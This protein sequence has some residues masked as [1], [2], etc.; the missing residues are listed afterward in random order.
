VNDERTLAAA[1]AI[2]HA[3][4]R[5]RR[6][7]SHVA[8]VDLCV[9][10]RARPCMEIAMGDTESGGAAANLGKHCYE[11]RKCYTCCFSTL[12][13]IFV[14]LLSISWDTIAPTEYGLLRNGLTGTVDMTTVYRSGRYFTGPNQRFI[15]FPANQITLSYGNR[16]SLGVDEQ[17]EIRARTGADSTQGAASSGGQPVTFSL[18]F[19]YTL[20]PQLV[21][22]VYQTFGTQ[23]ETPYLRFSQQAI[24]NVA[25]QFTPRAFWNER[26]SVERAMLD[27]VNRTL[28][29]NGFATC[30]QLQLRSVG[31]QS[32]YEQTIINIQLQ[33]QLRVTKSYQLEVTRV[34]KEVDLMQSE[35]DAKVV[36]V[37]AEAA[38]ERAVI[39]GEANAKAL[40]REQS[41]RATMY[42]RLR[43]HL[44]WSA[45]EFLQY[46]K[47][48]A[49]NSQPQ[50]NVVVGVNPLGSVV[51]A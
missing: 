46:I 15:R 48:K 47:M 17:A 33:E 29:D 4:L 43:S 50:S 27:A 21:P 16:T 19:Q 34:V 25:Q 11:Q 18:S 41:A 32:S 22:Q 24:T 28:F 39:E 45:A 10:R 14:I 38:R 20:N 51:A 37:N 49:L 31:F 3:S 12:L 9:R 8:L 30:T 23:W 35:T 40:Q 2:A 44:G 5:W 6:L 7:H 26:A 42:A 36:E 13:L 1:A